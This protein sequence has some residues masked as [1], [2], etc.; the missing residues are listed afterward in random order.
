MP[1]AFSSTVDEGTL[2]DDETDDNVRSRDFVQSLERGLAIIRVFNAEQPSMTV[3]EIAQ[4]VGLTRAAVRR[5]L[6]TLG[7]L[8]YVYARNNRFE[9]TPRVLELG[10]AY[11]SALSFPDIA[12]P[13]LEQL[14]A[15]TGEASEGSILYGGDV[16]YVVRVPGP[17]LMTISVNIGARRPAYATAMGRALLANLPSA[18]LDT[19]LDTYTLIPVLPRTITDVDALRAELNRVREDGYALVN[20]ELEE[21]L[22]AIAVPVRD[23]T[24]RV[25]AAINLSTHVGRKSVKEMRALVPAVRAA[26]ADIEVGLRNSLSWPD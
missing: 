9:L 6:L 14:V 1:G 16:V 3:S 8:G 7:E 17:A 18:D 4:Q 11:L 5:F 13:R 19:Y 2:D 23:R 10:Y 22:I 20:Q 24:G 21:G 12:L 25:R 26:A 15:E